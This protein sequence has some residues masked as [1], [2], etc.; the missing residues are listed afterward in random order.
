MAYPPAAVANAF[1]DLARTSHGTLD[2]M[3]VQKLVYFAHGWHLGRD[4]GPLISEPIEAWDYGPVVPT[5]YRDL[6]PYGAGAITDHVKEFEPRPEG[7]FRLVAPAVVDAAELSFHQRI[8]EVYGRLSATQL[9]A[10][11]HLPETPWTIVRTQNPGARG[12]VIPDALMKVYF[13]KLA[14]TN[15]RLA[16]TSTSR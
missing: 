4:S 14:A 7:G 16:A 3:K 5:L 8:W 9:S 11:T 13:Q 6:K 1:L 12:A 10:M 15:A 2:P